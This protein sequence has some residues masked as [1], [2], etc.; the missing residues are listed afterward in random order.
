MET[1]LVAISIHEHPEPCKVLEAALGDLSVETYF[2]EGCPAA[3]D[4]IAQYQ[5]LLVFV[6]HAIWR[7]SHN[8]IVYMARAADQYFSIV[9]VGSTP[10]IEMYVSAI[11]QGAFEFIAPPF[12]LE[13]LT[14]V[15]HSAA[16]D[17]HEL[18]ESFARM[19]L[20]RVA[21]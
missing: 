13:T 20:H 17:A 2:V 6:D 10:D 11:E 4:L 21:Q 16:L 18:R 3:R 1:P 14:R 12:S 7:R 8:E 5:P 19:S 15:V 9:V